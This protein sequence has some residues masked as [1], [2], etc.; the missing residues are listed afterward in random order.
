MLGNLYANHDFVQS[1]KLLNESHILEKK[2]NILSIFDIHCSFFISSIHFFIPIA[3]TPNPAAIHHFHAIS[4]NWLVF[5]SSFDSTFHGDS[6]D[7]SKLPFNSPLC[8]RLE[9][10][11]VSFSL[12]NLERSD[13]FFVLSFH[14]S[15][16]SCFS[17][18][19]SCFVNSIFSLNSGMEKSHVILSF[20]LRSLAF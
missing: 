4:L 11:I 13:S 20:F 8:S 16:S 6:L 15:H 14:K 3:T 5:S 12:I 7:N 9:F 19:S 1:K 17:F 2:P 10:F 18:A